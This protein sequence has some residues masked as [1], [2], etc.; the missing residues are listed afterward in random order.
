MTIELQILALTLLLAIIGWF[1]RK[2]FRDMER[3]RAED[4]KKYIESTNNLTGAIDKLESTMGALY[5][6]L[7]DFKI[8][9]EG[10]LAV[11]EKTSREYDRQQKWNAE[12][13]ADHDGQIK[14]IQE[15]CKLIQDNKRQ[16]SKE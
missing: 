2:W 12:T 13:L 9:T 4:A 10:R 8:N 14:V 11:V 5:D 15:R 1:A 16:H 6:T 3:D 7:N